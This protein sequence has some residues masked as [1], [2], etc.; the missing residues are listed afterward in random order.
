[1]KQLLLIFTFVLSV[2]SLSFAQ[3][4][5]VYSSFVMNDYFYNPAIAGSKD[6]TLATFGYRSQWM[7]FDDAPVNFNANFYGSLKNK[8]KHGYGISLTNEN[9]G[10]TNRTGFYLNYAYHIRFSDK[11]RLGLGVRPGFIQY[12]IKLYD[13][14]VADQGDEVLTGSVFSANA[15]DVNAGF[16]LYGKDFF[17]MGSFNHLLT[18]DI[19]LTNYNDALAF[20]LNFIG[21]YTFHVSKKVDLQPSVMV[22]HVRPV[23]D[24][25]TGMLKA[26][27]SKK[28]W[29]AL[30][31]R[32]E[33]AVG[34]AAGLLI[35]ERFG[36][37]YGYD[38]SISGLRKQQSGSHEIM[39]SFVVTKKKPTLEEEDDKL[40][41]SIMDKIQEE[42]QRKKEGGQPAPEAPTDSAF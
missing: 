27:F 40:N 11:I 2:C 25:W 34:I 31:Y 6:V 37:G 39:L 28:Y 3:Q 15:I 33:D 5:G 21:G 24:Q 16:N 10:I 12:N 38:Y 35:R 20:H 30:I 19:R 22:K 13:A 17:L 1:M 32:S 7:G 4:Q 8:M 41:K 23:P 29:G 14:Q 18:N 42:E 9:M 26:T 36:I